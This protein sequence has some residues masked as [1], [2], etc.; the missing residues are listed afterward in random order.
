MR[1]FIGGIIIVLV[2]W[3]WI[4]DSVSV[5]DVTDWVADH[6]EAMQPVEGDK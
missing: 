1:N 4:D 6:I 2:L 3:V 5:R